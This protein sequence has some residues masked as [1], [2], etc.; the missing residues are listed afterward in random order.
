ML[1]M[2]AYAD[3][4][5]EQR[6]LIYGHSSVDRNDAEFY[7]LMVRRLE[8]DTELMDGIS[9]A[10][11]RYQSLGVWTTP[12]Q[13]RH[14]NILLEFQRHLFP[15][16]KGG[17]QATSFKGSSTAAER[18]RQCWEKFK[19]V[20]SPHGRIPEMDMFVKQYMQSRA[21]ALMLQRQAHALVGFMSDGWP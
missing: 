18:R 19:K 8:T 2:E 3:R 16:E 7:L 14:L 10:V 15:G 12:E 20:S 9:L 1:Q 4:T 13:Q 5:F 21:S 11:E 17:V 6:M